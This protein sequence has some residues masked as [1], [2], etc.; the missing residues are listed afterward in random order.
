MDVEVICPRCRRTNYPNREN[1]GVGLRGIDFFNKARQLTCKGCSRPL[2]S[3][4]G[5]GA[6][7]TKCR[8]CKTVVE[9]GSIEEEISSKT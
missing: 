4:I 2:L 6:I 1:Q 8:Y 5:E 7:Q 9:Y 3:F